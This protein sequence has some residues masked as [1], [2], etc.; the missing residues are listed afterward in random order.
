MSYITIIILSIFAIVVTIIMIIKASYPSYKYNAKDA[1][2]IIENPKNKNVNII[3]ILKLSAEKYPNVTALK[4]K[5]GK[6]WKSITYFEYY[7]KVKKF[8]QS[9]KY[10]LGSSV[11]VGILGFNSPGWIYAHL[12]TMYNGGI[13]VG[14]YPSSTPDACKYIINNTNIELLVVEDAI[15]LEKIVGLNDSPLKLIIY[16]SPINEEIIDQFQIPV[17]SMGN[18]MTQ[19]IKLSKITNFNDVATIIYT[20]GTT[21]NP[22]GAMLSHKNIMHSLKQLINLIKTKSSISTLGYEQFIS[23]LPLNHIAAQMM[24]I[25][26][27]I[28]S[29]ST[30]WFADKDALK[31]T[32]GTTIKEVKPTIFMGVPRVWEKIRENI[33]LKLDAI[34]W[35]GQLS[36]T[37]TPWKIIHDVGLEKCKLCITTGAPISIH[38]KNYFDIIG[39]KLYDIYGMSET[40]G[41]ISISAPGVSRI[42]S[43]GLP[44]MDV[45]IANDGEIL[46]KGNNLFMG[47]YEDPHETAK[48]FTKDKWFK[49]GDLGKLDVNGFLYVT[50]RKKELIITAG[51]EN[52]SVVPI[53][54]AL[55]EKLNK[56]C[57]YVCVIG[58]KKKFLVALFNVK[59]KQKIS[60]DIA[61]DAINYANTKAPSQ[62]HTIKKYTVVTNKFKI[63]SELTPTYKLK[64]DYIQNKYW[65]QIKKLYR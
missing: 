62:A 3:E 51:G 6:T 1:C 18:F 16:Y 46:V 23:Y 52:I 8:A 55:M 39:F 45:K 28:A 47:Y 44:T 24:D 4:I 17:I 42:Y 58:N 37:F 19:T 21:D 59:P 12:G 64:R 36:K 30:V 33:D 61:M 65:K 57:D 14:L 49:T 5:E 15:Q 56:Y 7:K 9:L 43:V 60:N 53:E 63:G 27:P 31:S 26:L 41:P 22:K 20:S 29:M 35:K 10:W 40:A 32:L 2:S 11:N 50:G 25:Y 13:S 38:T 54:T 34:G 48:S